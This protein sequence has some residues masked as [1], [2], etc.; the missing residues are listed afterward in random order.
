MAQDAHPLCTST[1]LKVGDNINLC[2]TVIVRPSAFPVPTNNG[3]VSLSAGAKTIGPSPT[4][5]SL[6]A[7]VLSSGASNP[8]IDSQEIRRK[9]EHDDV[10]DSHMFSPSWFMHHRKEHWPDIDVAGMGEDLASIY[11]KVKATGL[12]NALAAQVPLPSNLNIE[13]WEKELSLPDED[14]QLLGLIKHGFPLGYAGPISRSSGVDNHKIAN[15]FKK[16][17]DAFMNTEVGLGQVIGPMPDVPF[18]QW[19]HISPLMSREKRD[20]DNRRIII[21]MTFPNEYSVNA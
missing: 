1:A 4:N 7:H 12:P 8:H 13:M 21:E 10:F 18:I 17:I 11:S 19:A 6:D 20:S 2:D 15:D 5:I 3:S 9:C 14:C 16:H